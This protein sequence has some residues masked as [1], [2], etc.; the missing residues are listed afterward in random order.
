MYQLTLTVNLNKINTNHNTWVLLEMVCRRSVGHAI[1]VPSASPT[2]LTSDVGTGTIKQQYQWTQTKIEEKETTQSFKQ[3]SPR[4]ELQTK[5]KLF[6]LF[7]QQIWRRMSVMDL[8]G[9]VM[10]VEMQPRRCQNSARE[11]ARFGGRRK[12]KVKTC[13]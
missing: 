4:T 13:G 11:H 5:M 9:E 3:K 6:K 1:N 2:S 10:E 12:M 7:P 8:N